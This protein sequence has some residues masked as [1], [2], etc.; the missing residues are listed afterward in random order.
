MI[1]HVSL[2][3]VLGEQ[4]LHKYANMPPQLSPITLDR[5]GP[6]LIRFTQKHTHKRL[7]TPKGKQTNVRLIGQ[8]LL[9]PD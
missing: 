4:E 6:S 1:C 8:A 5:L 9:P 2:S 3:A 7:L